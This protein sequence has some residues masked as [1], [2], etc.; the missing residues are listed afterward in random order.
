[1]A[2]DVHEEWH[3]EGEA[4]GDETGEGVGQQLA[5]RTE[6]YEQADQ[7]PDEH[8]DGEA[9]ADGGHLRRLPPRRARR[10]DAGWWCAGGRLE[11]ASGYVTQRP[12]SWA[13][14]SRPEP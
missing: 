4:A 12:C 2:E 11:A 7:D 10:L 1:V 5:G 14:P 6:G 3:G 8:G 9:S 13:T